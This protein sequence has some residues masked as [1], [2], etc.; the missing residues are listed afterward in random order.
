MLAHE[1]L[2]YHE[3]EIEENKPFQLVLYESSHYETGQYNF[4][5]SLIDHFKI[6]SDRFKAITLGLKMYIRSAQ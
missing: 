4:P 2:A 3:V 5:I 1:A 6:V